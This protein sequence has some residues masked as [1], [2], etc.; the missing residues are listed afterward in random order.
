MILGL[1]VNLNSEF[2]PTYC[3]SC[4]YNK[5]CKNYYVE[6]PSCP[7]GYSPVNQD[8]A[9]LKSTMKLGESRAGSILRPEILIKIGKAAANNSDY[10]TASE[11]YEKALNIDSNNTEAA[12]LLKRTKYIVNGDRE[13]LDDTT[14]EEIKIS[15]T[16]EKRTGM[17]PLQEE[18]KIS[19]KPKAQYEIDPELRSQDASKVYHVEQEDNEDE[20]EK[21]SKDVAIQIKIA[22][23][24]RNRNI[25][26]GAGIFVILLM[27]FLL[28]WFGYLQI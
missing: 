19:I 3:H 28:W 10:E 5:F 22:A 9:V 25:G 7:H 27:I 15:E 21:V 2:M 20:L 18:K 17:L 26:L 6:K 13:K 11:C 1:S 8:T 24:K 12:F 23:T 14:E 4:P 16:E